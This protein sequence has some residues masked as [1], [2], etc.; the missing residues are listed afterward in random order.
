MINS[1]VLLTVLG[2][3][4][5]FWFDSLRTRERAKIIC[6]QACGQFKLQLL[7]ETIALKQIRLR[8][9]HGGQLIFQR[10]YQFEFYEGDNIRQQGSIIM[11][12]T[13]LEIL[14]LPGYLN[15]VISPV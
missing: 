2:C 1:V 12:G 13:S 7:D 3:L 14:E 8:R 5:W 11:R 15:R 10:L 4:T 6:Q 9:R